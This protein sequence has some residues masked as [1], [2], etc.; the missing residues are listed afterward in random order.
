MSV[1][2]HDDISPRDY[3]LSKGWELSKKTQVR[4]DN[5]RIPCPACGKYDACDMNVRTGQWKCLRSSCEQ[6]GGF[7]KM[8]TLLNDAYDIEK[9]VERKPFNVERFEADLVKA[10]RETRSDSPAEGETIDPVELWHRDLL[11]ADAAAPA[12]KYLEERG[13]TEDVIKLAKLGW[14]SSPPGNASEPVTT[15]RRKKSPAAR[16]K[17]PAA[18][19]AVPASPESSSSD[20]KP[21]R[22]PKGK[23]AAKR[24]SRRAS[25]PQKRTGPGSGGLITIPYFEDGKVVLVKLRWVPPEPVDGKNGKVRRYQRIAGGRTVLYQPFGPIDPEKPVVLVGGE[26]DA[27]SAGVALLEL[28]ESLNVAATSA[29]EGGW[30]EEFGDELDAVEDLIVIYDSDAGGRGGAKKVAEAMGRHRVRIGKWPEGHNDANDALRAG[31]LEGFSMVAVMRDAV[32][33]VA[34][35]VATAAA[36]GKDYLARRADTSRAQSW[37]TGHKDMDNL[38]GGIRGRRGDRLHW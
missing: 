19:R 10:F 1:T 37:T 36:V 23:A 20:E 34:A 24:R 12:R 31:D 21:Q 17:K 32:S 22:P 25:A 26:F 33:P 18:A 30:S 2:T 27:L 9:P 14:A 11:T 15:S 16:R 28:G 6:G 5:Y 8:R 7:Y 4:K 13:I 3:A 35:A 29:G 38:T